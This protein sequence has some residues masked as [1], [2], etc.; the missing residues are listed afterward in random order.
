M[1]AARGWGIYHGLAG[2]SKQD[3]NTFELLH[4]PLV[5]HCDS[6]SH[7]SI[8]RRIPLTLPDTTAGHNQIAISYCERY[9]RC[10]MP[11]QLNVEPI[12]YLPEGV[13]SNPSLQNEE[14]ADR[15]RR[16]KETPNHALRSQELQGL[17]NADPQNMA[18]DKALVQEEMNANSHVETY[19]F[20][21][22]LGVVQG[23]DPTFRSWFDSGSS[24]VLV[25][26]VMDPDA[27]RTRYAASSIFACAFATALDNRAPVMPLAFFCT[28]YNVRTGPDMFNFPVPALGGVDGVLRGLCS[29]LVHQFRDGAGRNR[30]SVLNLA[31][32]NTYLRTNN[33]PLPTNNLV[34][35]LQSLI[36]AVA[37]LK[38]N[39]MLVCIVDGIDT[40]CGDHCATEF[41]QLVTGL[42]SI[43]TQLSRDYPAGN[44]FGRFRLKVILTH[45]AKSDTVN[46]WLAPGSAMLMSASRQAYARAYSRDVM[47]STQ[48][49]VLGAFR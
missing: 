21:R 39:L 35:L 33:A 1:F 38:S 14:H 28:K 34:G 18:Y 25:I 49:F 16:F 48:S 4:L 42:Q 44:S 7:C 32:V 5:L 24:R 3:Q 15:L 2:F 17:L 10:T 6:N 31:R 20:G 12:Y 9:S 46:S 40:L 30:D 29:Q 13:P 45:P 26:H 47:L 22:A 19:W 37:M 27:A 8:P 36:N 43:C 11:E 41:R 23:Q